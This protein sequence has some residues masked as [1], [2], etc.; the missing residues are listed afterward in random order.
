MIIGGYEIEEAK[1]RYLNVN[2][3]G[4]YDFGVLQECYDGIGAHV[5]YSKY[6]IDNPQYIG[7]MPN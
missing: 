4:V 5:H 3:Y 6:V 7:E 1:I 2:Y